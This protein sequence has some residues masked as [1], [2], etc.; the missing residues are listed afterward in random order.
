MKRL[1]RIINGGKSG[2]RLRGLEEFETPEFVGRMDCYRRLPWASNRPDIL[3]KAQC[4][5]VRN[6]P[7]ALPARRRARQCG[8]AA[9]GGSG[10]FRCGDGAARLWPG[11]GQVRLLLRHIYADG[12]NVR[13]V[14]VSEGLA[15][16]YG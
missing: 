9:A 7:A 3:R 13:D 2:K 1:F 14:L 4:F 15:R 6:A 16:P 10:Q 5:R 11:P 12:V 8:D